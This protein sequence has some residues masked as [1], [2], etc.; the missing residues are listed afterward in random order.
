MAKLVSE[1]LDVFAIFNANASHQVRIVDFLERV[2]DYDTTNCKK[3]VNYVKQFFQTNKHGLIRL[4]QNNTVAF[5]EEK[6]ANIEW[7][8]QPLSFCF[9]ESLDD[10]QQML[11]A[12]DDMLTSILALDATKNELQHRLAMLMCTQ[13]FTQDNK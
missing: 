9:C 12:N 6:F 10:A 5:D 4:D 3:W 8:K 7:R 2:A 13:D 1:L 11:P